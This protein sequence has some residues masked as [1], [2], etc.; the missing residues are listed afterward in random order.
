[1]DKKVVLVTGASRGIGK[2]ISLEFAKE[3]YSVVINYR[4]D[5][6]Q[7]KEVVDSIVNSGGEAFPVKAD[8]S[9]S[10]E[11][12]NMV[13]ETLNKYGGIDVLVNNAGIIEDSLIINMDEEKWDK[14]INTNLKG[15]FL[16]CKY[17]SKSMIKNKKGSIINISSISGV[18]GNF[19]QSNYSAS[20]AGI[21]GLTKSLAKELGRY[22]ICVNAVLPGYHMT[23]LTVDSEKH[24]KTYSPG[25]R[26]KEESVL[27]NFTDLNE[28]AEFIV[29]LAGLKSVSGQ[30]FNIDSRVI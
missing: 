16:C 17:V 25:I 6:K 3:K 26:A 19:G 2:A 5:E 12:N 14:V 30:V 27:K 22:N 10:V 13:N 7:A 18:R 28:V 4:N 15:V 9:L 23:G 29:F 11:V 20:K 21:I 24:A 8:V 1:M